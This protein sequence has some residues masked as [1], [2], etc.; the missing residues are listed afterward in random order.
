MSVTCNSV[1]WFV[2]TNEF[3]GNTMPMCAQ[4][5]ADLLAPVQSVITDILY[6]LKYILCSLCRD[7]NIESKPN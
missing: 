7:V 5:P 1:S 4:Y 6:V 2:K 3:N